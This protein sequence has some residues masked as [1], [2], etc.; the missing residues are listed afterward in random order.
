MGGGRR[1]GE[2]AAMSGPLLHTAAVTSVPV[3]LKVCVRGDIW[4]L[5]YVA[6]HSLGMG[7]VAVATQG[8]GLPAVAA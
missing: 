3:P 1:E 8:L 4:G 7:I 5:V 6:T 2:A